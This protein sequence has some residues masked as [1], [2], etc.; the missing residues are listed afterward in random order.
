[1]DTLFRFAE[2][3]VTL[4]VIVVALALAIA[5]FAAPILFI[6]CYAGRWKKRAALVVRFSYVWPMALRC[7]VRSRDL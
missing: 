5:L 4:D 1:M 3:I 7:S 6:A 2:V